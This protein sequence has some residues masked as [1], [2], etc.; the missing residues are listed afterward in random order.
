MATHRGNRGVHQ[1]RRHLRSPQGRPGERGRWNPLALGEPGARE[2]VD[3]L[4]VDEAGQLS[5]ANVV[6]VSTRARASSC[7]AIPSSSNS[8]SRGATPRERVSR[9][10]SMSWGASD[11]AVRPGHLPRRDLALGAGRLCFTS[12]VFYEGRLQPASGCE[13]QRL[14]G[15]APFEGSGLWVVPIEHEATATA[16]P[17][18]SKWSTGWSPPS[19]AQALRG[20]AP[21]AS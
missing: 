3:V 21:R 14:S 1:G 2:A 15:T 12:E 9:C 19:F 4:F 11:D 8:R 13:R 17:R 5:L 18:K 20:G 7:S 16:R 6:A 10:S